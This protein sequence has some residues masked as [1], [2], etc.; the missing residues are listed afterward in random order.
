MESDALFLLMTTLAILL[1]VCHGQTARGLAV[2]MFRSSVRLGYVYTDRYVILD[3]QNRLRGG[4]SQGLL[5][6]PAPLEPCLLGYEERLYH[7]L[8][9]AYVMLAHIW[10]DLSG[11]ISTVPERVI[12][13]SN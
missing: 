11:Q 10:A 2:Q 3:D 5:Y 12:I 6:G 8:L 1:L 7:L 9:F 4:G 13:R